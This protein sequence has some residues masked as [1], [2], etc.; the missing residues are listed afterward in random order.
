MVL[1]WE[2]QAALSSLHVVALFTTV[3]PTLHQL[4][5]H[6][7]RLVEDWAFSMLF[8]AFEKVTE[9]LCWRGWTG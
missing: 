8:V 5:L 6:K 1:D 3:G 2:G 7:C 4:A 9:P